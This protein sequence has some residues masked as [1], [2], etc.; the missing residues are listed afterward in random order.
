MR[1]SKRTVAVV[2]LVVVIIAGAATLSAQG[3]NMNPVVQAL[4]A[5]QATLDNLVTTVNRIATAVTEGNVLITPPILS[6][7]DQL[8]CGATNV[9]DVQHTI[10][11]QVFD[12]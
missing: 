11:V 6:F 3:S 8:Y 7:P 9:D 2:S 5:I 4:A 12:T 1:I 10:T